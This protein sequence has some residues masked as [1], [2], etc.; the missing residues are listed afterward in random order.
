M[1]KIIGI[2]L[3]SLFLAGCGA[4]SDP[5][6][7]TPKTTVRI[8]NS[9]S[10]PEFPDI[11][12]LP[13]LNILAYK[14]DLP[15]DLNELSVISSTKCRNKKIKTKPREDKPYIIVPVETQSSEWWRR[16]GENPIFPESNIYIGFD[17]IQW[18]IIINNATKLKERIGQ[19]KQR[20]AEI[21]SQRREWREKAAAE[22]TRLLN[23]TA[24]KAKIDE[25]TN[26]IKPAT[27]SSSFLNRLFN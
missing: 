26:D 21:N 24:I 6:Y 17:Q 2:L 1:K 3:I 13:E 16:C 14:P 20:I 7:F 12:P 10:Y 9:V 19:Y 4:T 15:R 27:E 5:K 8:I 18:N 11:T 23:E 25:K 22:R